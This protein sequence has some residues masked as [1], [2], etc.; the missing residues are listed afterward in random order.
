[1]SDVDQ[2]TE[3]QQLEMGRLRRRAVKKLNYADFSRLP[4]VADEV[5]FENSPRKVERVIKFV[6]P[7][8][9]L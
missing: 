1:M 5:V 3:L 9:Y 6:Q 7:I 8:H 2:T 4:Q